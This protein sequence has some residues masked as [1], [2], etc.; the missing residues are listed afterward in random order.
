M[1]K[2]YY[3][4]PKTKKVKNNRKLIYDS[5][6]VDAYEIQLASYGSVFS[7]MIAEKRERDVMA[8]CRRLAEANK[9]LREE[10]DEYEA[11]RREKQSKW[12]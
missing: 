2:C 1:P 3:E 5:A 6:L 12:D 11:N 4:M 7:D 8:A 10:E 9:K